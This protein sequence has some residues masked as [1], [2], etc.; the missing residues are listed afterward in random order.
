MDGTTADYVVVSTTLD[1]E[2]KADELAEKIVEAR[3]AACV[4]QTKVKSTYRWEGRI[5]KADEIVVAA[6]TRNAQAHDLS[7][8]I[9]DNH[10]Y[11]VPEVI[12]T[13]IMSGDPAYLTWIRN[14][15]HAQ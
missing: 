4:Q 2:A 8:F 1:D 12:V 11:D 5:E 15:T 6:K 7:H 13:P 9:K 10:T 3:L 14:E